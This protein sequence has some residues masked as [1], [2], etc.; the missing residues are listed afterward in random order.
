[1]TTVPRLA[2]RTA[3]LLT[4]LTLLAGVP[5]LLIVTAGWPLPDHIPTGSEAGQWLT[6]PLPDTVYADAAAIAGWIIWAQFTAHVITALH[7][8]DRSPRPGANTNRGPLRALAALLIAGVL[9]APAQA[10]AAPAT[11]A[12]PTAATTHAIAAPPTDQ[13]PAALRTAP[14][15][16]PGTVAASGNNTEIRYVVRGQRYHAIVRPTDTMSKIAK[17][18]LGDSRR[19]P[20]ICKLN[21]H[22]HYPK[23]GGT[24]RDCDLIYPKWDLRLPDDATPPATAT[25]PAATRPSPAT[26][27]ATTPAPSPAADLDQAPP[28]IAPPQAPPSPVSAAAPQQDASVTE[29]HARDVTDIKPAA[30]QVGDGVQ[31]PGGWTPVG[32]A[33]ALAAAAALVLRR[34]RANY[35]PQTVTAELTDAPDPPT[36]PTVVGWIRHALRRRTTTTRSADD[37]TPDSIAAGGPTGA[38]LAGAGALPLAAGLGLVG[39]GALDAARGML[40]ATLS[41]GHRDDPDAQGQAVMPTDTLQMLLGGAARTV[42]PIRRLHI[43]D[44]IGEAVAH[45]EEE[46]IHRSRIIADAQTTEAADLHNPRAYAE[47]L[48]QLL[49]I[50]GTPDPR[51]HTRL[52]TAVALGE[53]VGIGTV[54]IG[55][56]PRGT[57]LE[58][59]AD[60]TTD[61]TGRRLA[62]LDTGTAAQALE[63]LREAHGDAPAPAPL[64]PAQPQ[65]AVPPRPAVRPQ[66]EECGQRPPVRIKVLGVPAVL[67]HAGRPAPR[68]RTAARELMV[69][70]VMHRDGAAIDDIMEAI[71]P[72]ATVTRAGERL[73]TD[74]ANLRKVIRTVAGPSVDGGRIEPVTNSGGHY[75]LNADLVDADWW[76]IADEYAQIAAAPDDQHRLK[77]LHAALAEITGPLAQGCLY[78]WSTLD[79]ERVRRAA[80]TIYAQTAAMYA[81]SDPHQARSLLNAACAVDPLSEELACRAMRAAAAHSDAGAVSHRLAVLTRDLH[82]AGLELSDDTARLA[83]QL[84]TDL[85]TE[86]GNNRL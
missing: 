40:V 38:E 5:W 86:P 1:M 49:L 79:E 10:L 33:A 34:R 22:R 44:T 11:T 9:A 42:T 4:L 58:V 84:L 13:P 66:R 46:I 26:P 37:S 78:E 17:Q 63:I 76:T 71:Y 6:D 29:H 72:D 67:D 21:L 8:R 35:V 41:S 83:Q 43:T 3:S 51:W 14:A 61:A 18:W 73:S 85:T 68:L 82:Q 70:L 52:A 60:G 53:S 69:Y 27:A 23:V 28:A 74:V 7:R 39:P 59:A 81:E 32:L 12:P 30:N 62:V 56:W 75:R 47:P 2:V 20:E 16:T 64:A 45:L 31:L 54:I 80:L 24:L 55:E 15:P 48:P 57:T 50:A 65:T 36:L 25:P 77:H 19:W